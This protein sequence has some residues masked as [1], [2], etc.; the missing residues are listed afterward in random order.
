MLGLWG[1]KVLRLEGLAQRAPGLAKGFRALGLSGVGFRF[2]TPCRYIGAP[3]DEDPP[4]LELNKNEIRT[5]KCWLQEKLEFV[6]LKGL[7]SY[8]RLLFGWV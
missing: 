6:V 1:C 8:S 4:Y 2:E 5:A 7:N 3:W